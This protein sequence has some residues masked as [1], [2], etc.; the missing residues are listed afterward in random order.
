MS[1]LTNARTLWTLLLVQVLI[2]IGFVSVM[3]VYDFVLMDEMWE[4]DAIRSY[5]AELSAQQKRAH[6]WTTATLDVLYPLAYG[7]FYAGLALRF[8]PR[9][10]G[11]LVLPAIAVIPV[12]LAEGVV[13]VMALNG[14]AAIVNHKAWI[15]PLKLVLFGLASLIALAGL[16][17]GLRRKY[18]ARSG[19]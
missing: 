1:V 18:A 16:A 7:A 17:V 4:P 6:V 10:G 15:T 8:L 5:L 19:S 14:D 12:D 3:T 11:L 2:W 13:Q 9:L